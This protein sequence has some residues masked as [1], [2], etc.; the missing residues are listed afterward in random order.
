MD[1]IAYICRKLL[2]SMAALIPVI[3]A[4][5]QS[6]RA[7]GGFPEWRSPGAHNR[8]YRP[9]SRPS[10]QRQAVGRLRRPGLD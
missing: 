9:H 10:P 1:E 4:Q 3:S 2:S 8:Q 7:V 5:A 6:H